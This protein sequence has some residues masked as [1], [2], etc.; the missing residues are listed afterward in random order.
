MSPWVLI[1]ATLASLAAGTW[2]GSAIS[3]HRQGRWASSLR[4]T[5]DLPDCCGPREVHGEKWDTCGRC[6]LTNDSPC[7]CHEGAKA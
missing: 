2:L 6:G 5:C 7:P 3:N 4:D 1:A